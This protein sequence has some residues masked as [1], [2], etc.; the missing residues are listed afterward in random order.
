LIL[1][2]DRIKA[3]TF[4]TSIVLIASITIALM[5]LS[6]SIN[7][8]VAQAPYLNARTVPVATDYNTTASVFCNDGDGMISGGYSIGFLSAQSAFDTMVYSNHPIQ[9]INQSEYFEGWKAGLVNKGNTTAE[10]TSMV[11]CLNLTLTP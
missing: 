3:I 4:A 6:T 7:E 2:K 11:L 10:I 8:T 1:S 5:V 9:Q